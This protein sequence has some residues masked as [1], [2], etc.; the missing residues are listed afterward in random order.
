MEIHDRWETTAFDLAPLA[1][2]TGPFIRRELLGVWWHHRRGDGELQLLDSGNGF[3]PLCRWNGAVRFV[4]EADLIDYHSP[5][6]E[7]ITDLVAS[8][9]AGLE[10]GT[11]L[12]F[13]SLPREAADAV[14]AGLAG[15]GLAVEPIQHEIAAVLPLPATYDDWLASLGRKDRHEVR[16]K[17]RRFE[18]AGGAPTLTRRS[19]VEA[20]ATFSTLHRKAEGSKGGFMTEAM[21]GFFESLHE[22]AGAV[23]DVLEGPGG[24]PIAAAFGFEDEE[25]YYLYNSGYDPE[26]RELSPG[27]VMLA[28]LVRR[29]IRSGRQT[30]DFLKGDE[31]Y[32]F[33]HGARPRP[34][35]E[36]RA[37]TGVSQ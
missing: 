19:G 11:A 22:H 25:A 21:Q 35:Y 10:A 20:V 7:G 24:Q 14:T 30:F 2:R 9:V 32:K 5:L 33:R 18:A 3:V 16:R 37:I 8:Y 13:D 27:I 23:V 26:A 6:G 34:L 12:H 15:A 1:P 17:L 36:I 29:A 28:A 4:G 31:T